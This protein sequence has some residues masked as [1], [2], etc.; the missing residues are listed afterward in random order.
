MLMAPFYYL[1]RKILIK[2]TDQEC[3]N[4]FGKNIKTTIPDRDGHF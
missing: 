4:S 3:L 1:K 2:Y